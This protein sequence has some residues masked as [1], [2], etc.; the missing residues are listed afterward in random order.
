MEYNLTSYV[1]HY[2]N[3]L[4]TKL[5]KQTLKDLRKAPFKQHKFHISSK[6]VFK[7]LSG[8]QE[9]D[10]V[11]DFQGSTYNQLMDILWKSIQRYVSELNFSWYPGWNGY[12]HIN[13]N[14]YSSKNK[15]KMREHCDHI[16]SLF[17]GE[18]R[19]IPVLSIVG[20]L[21]DNFK[22]GEFIMFQ[23]KEYKLKEGSLLIFPSIFLYPHRVEPV[24]KGTRYSLV[25]WVY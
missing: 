10:R 24:T 18:K 3:A 14:R 12:S 17:E 15:A 25:S 4:D 23:D 11:F 1:K 19:G 16:H 13:F 2:T 21:N 7:A 20:L 8:K 6:N 5:C 9:L 22:G